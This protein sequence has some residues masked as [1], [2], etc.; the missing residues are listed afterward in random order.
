[1]FDAKYKGSDGIERNTAFNNKNVI[2]IL[3]GREWK[4]GQGGR[5]AFTIDLKC[6]R[7][8][9][10]YYTP[11]DLDKSIA[12]GGE[13]LDETRY[14]AEQLGSYFRLDTR[15]GFRLN[16]PKR[17]RSQTIYLDIQNITNNENVFI[18]RYNQVLK[19]TGTLNQVGFFPDILYRLQF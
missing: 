2:N 12:A 5:N 6:T 14:N 8:G 16:N 15:F 19:K 10:R 4:M 7:S 3:A 13:V 9:G 18:Q 17:K 1:V 11:V